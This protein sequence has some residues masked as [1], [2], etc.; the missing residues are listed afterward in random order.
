MPPLQEDTSSASGTGRDGVHTTS[1]PPARG[2]DAAAEVAAAR[3]F[4]ELLERATRHPD[5]PEHL[6]IL[7]QAIAPWLAEHW[8]IAIQVAAH[9]F[10]AARAGCGVATEFA[11]AL[12]TAGLREIIIKQGVTRD[13]LARL[14]AA[15]AAAAASDLARPTATRTTGAASDLAR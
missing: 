3:T 6:A 15:L 7:T 13:E 5:A 14:T 8:F 2:S 1:F 11:A 9:E 10:R 12:F 4:V